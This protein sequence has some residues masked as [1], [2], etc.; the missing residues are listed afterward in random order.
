MT[1]PIEF[2][3]NALVAEIIP[4]SLRDLLGTTGSASMFRL[5]ED[6]PAQS[7][8]IRTYLEDHIVGQRPAIDAI[9]KAL[10]RSTIRTD[11]RPIASMLFLGP[12]G[13]GKTE[14]TK[15]LQQALENEG[16]ETNRRHLDCSQLGRD[17][18]ASAFLLGSPAGYVGYADVAFFSPRH[19]APAGSNKVTI[20]VLDEL[21]K[22]SD[23]LP[24]VLLPALEE[25]KVTL[26]CGVTTS[27]AN[28]IVIATS[29]VGAEDMTKATKGATGFMSA[30]RRGNKTS[31]DIETAAL[32]GL[33][34][35]Y[36]HIPE[37][38]GRFTD[39]VVF[40]QH[41]HEGLLQVLDRSIDL[42]NKNYRE[43]HGTEICLTPDARK[44]I[45]SKIA[46]QEHLGARPLNQ[47]LRDLVEW[48]FSGYLN[49]GH[50]GKGKRL[51][52]CLE[53]ELD[54][55]PQDESTSRLAFFVADAPELVSKNTNTQLQIA[56]VPHTP[57]TAVQLQQNDYTI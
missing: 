40:T 37:F 24:E 12:T 10:D 25:G 47:A 39:T 15:V 8:E 44:H 55:G 21:E 17:H 18:E 43:K 42:K 50:V 52:A 28:T 23:A 46:G 1:T 51:I 32:E 29:N 20:L 27:F 54:G 36:Q 34:R 57:A 35:R 38:I 26:K 2:A 16:V 5:P 45:L 31:S 53:S 9:V 48:P 6:V 7:P 11:N 56:A 22:A 30:N 3:P 4:N 19:Y 13:S 33:K 41:D 14:V 49:A